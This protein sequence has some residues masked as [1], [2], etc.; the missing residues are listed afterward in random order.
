MNAQVVPCRK[1]WKQNFWLKNKRY[2]RYLSIHSTK[3]KE[4]FN[5][6]LIEKSLIWCAVI[7]DSKDKSREAM[8]KESYI[9][10]TN[11]CLLLLLLSSFTS[12]IS[13]FH[14]IIII[15]NTILSWNANISQKVKIDKSVQIWNL[16]I[17]KHKSLRF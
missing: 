4:I 9:S 1:H 14:L 13:L 5:G 17:A 15:G 6:K 11:G 8:S 3:N 10:I 2:Q 12:F 7:A 16:K